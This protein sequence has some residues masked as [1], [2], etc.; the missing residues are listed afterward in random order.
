MDK[1]DSVADLKPASAPTVAKENEIVLR[2][3]EMSP[4]HHQIA[5]PAAEDFLMHARIC[6]LMENYANI[7]SPTRQTQDKFDFGLLTGRSRIEL[8]GMYTQLSSN[9][10]G[11]VDQAGYNS[12]RSTKQLSNAAAT[13]ASAEDLAQNEPH[14]SILK[15]LLECSDDLVVEGYFVGSESD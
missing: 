12:Q 15:S 11:M 7:M 5:I 3:C 2:T 9:R 10:R 14:P 6:A 13:A 8:E 4:S 1:I